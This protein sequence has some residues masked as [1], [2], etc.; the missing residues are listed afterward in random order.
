[1]RLFDQGP[2]ASVTMLSV[3]QRK[4]MPSTI[5]VT[6]PPSTRF[7][8]FMTRRIVHC[9]PLLQIGGTQYLGG[10]SNSA[11]KFLSALPPRSR[12]ALHEGVR[13]PVAEFK[14]VAG[15]I[16]PHG[17]SAAPCD[18]AQICDVS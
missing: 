18:R 12:E 4:T 9:H 5:G 14:L 15:V 2:P 13:N 16:I 7:S 1:M 3:S 17:P 8:D 6:P 11:H 10:G